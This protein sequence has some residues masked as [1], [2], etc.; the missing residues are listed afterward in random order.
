MVKECRSKHSI[1]GALVGK[2]GFPQIPKERRPTIGSIATVHDTQPFPEQLDISGGIWS[3]QG[4]G[5]YFGIAKRLVEFNQNL[6]GYNPVVRI[7]D[8]RGEQCLAWTMFLT[9]LI[10]CIKQY[11]GIQAREPH[12]RK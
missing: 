5:E 3:G 11:I 2:I 9:I 10:R 4:L 6:V 8:C 7:R 1:V 12:R